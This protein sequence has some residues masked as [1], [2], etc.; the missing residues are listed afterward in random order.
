[1]TDDDA[2]LIARLQALDTCAVSDALD[3]LGLPCAVTG[4]AAQ[5]MGRRIAAG[6]S[7]SSDRPETRRVRP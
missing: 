1:M 3:T 6:P 5:T 7:R 4:I 2:R